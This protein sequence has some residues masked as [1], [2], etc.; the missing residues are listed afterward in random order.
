MT[1]TI[2]GTTSSR[3]C[4]HRLGPIHIS[5]GEAWIMGEKN[6]SFSGMEALLKHLGCEVEVLE[7]EVYESTDCK[8]T[9]PMFKVIFPASSKITKFPK[10]H[11]DSRYTADGNLR[12]GKKKNRRL[13]L[14]DRKGQILIPGDA[15]DHIVTWYRKA[16]YS[17]EL[18]DRGVHEVEKD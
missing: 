3:K 2:D 17:P 18:F 14:E 11:M 7:P 5:K 6:Q 9:L 1:I 4:R 10:D 13:S 15:S 12:K 16:G 8:V